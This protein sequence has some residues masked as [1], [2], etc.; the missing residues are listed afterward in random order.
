MGYG[1]HYEGISRSVFQGKGV[2][3]QDH[4]KRRTTIMIRN[5]HEIAPSNQHRNRL[6]SNSQN[7]C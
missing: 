4:G 3:G 1:V 2:G 5:I 6:S 7:H